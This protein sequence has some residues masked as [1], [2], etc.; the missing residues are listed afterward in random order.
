MQLDKQV[1]FWRLVSDAYD[2]FS[3][4]GGSGRYSGFEE[5]HPMALVTMLISGVTPPTNFSDFNNSHDLLPESIWFKT[6]GLPKKLFY[7]ILD[8]EILPNSLNEF[9]IFSDQ[10]IN[11]FSKND[12]LRWNSF[13]TTLKNV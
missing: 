2:Y 6:D 4:L 11:K 1:I 7:Q 8:K 12:Q 13:L 10:Y 3:K 5:W 9:L